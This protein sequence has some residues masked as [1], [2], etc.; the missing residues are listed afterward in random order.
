MDSRWDDKE[1]F[2]TAKDRENL[3]RIHEMTKQ[4]TTSYLRFDDLPALPPVQPPPFYWSSDNRAHLGYDLPHAIDFDMSLWP[5]SLTI[6]TQEESSSQS[7]SPFSFS[8]DFLD[9]LNLDDAFDSPPSQKTDK[10]TIKNTYHYLFQEI[11]KLKPSNALKA[12]TAITNDQNTP[13]QSDEIKQLAHE[14]QQ[15]ILDSSARRIQLWY[16]EEKRAQKEKT[17]DVKNQFTLKP[18]R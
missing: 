18:P 14:E 10:E 4:L 1:P 6:P 17:P 15:K 8:S 11:K 16:K 2:M 5:S 7:S 13:I 12:L 3:E 9:H